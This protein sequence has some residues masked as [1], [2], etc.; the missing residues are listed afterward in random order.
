MAGR[1]GWLRW[2][3]PGDEH[4]S[5]AVVKAV[6]ASHE[7]RNFRRLTIARSLVFA[8]IFVWL[9]VNYGWWVAA[10]NALILG[11]FIANG[12]VA[13]W[14]SAGRD[15]RGW[16]PYVV[17]LV[18]AVLL[19][20]TLIAPGRTYPDEWPWPT[21]LR[22]PSF[23][24]FLLLPAIATLS[25]RPIMVVWSSLCVAFVW[26][27]GTWLIARSEG[28]VTELPDADAANAASSQL[29]AYL[30]PNYVHLDDAVVRVFLTILIGAILAYGAYRA[31]TLM[32]EQAEVVRQR[33][34]LA[35]YVAPNMVEALAAVDRPMGEVRTHDAAVLFADIKGFTALAEAGSPVAAM[36]LLR[37]F[38]GRMA[39]CVFAHG[40]TLDKFIGDGLM[41]TFGTPEPQA[42]AADRAF[43]CGLA[44]LHAIETWQAT[45][46]AAG[47]PAIEVGI[48]IHY[49]PVIMG[50]IGGGEDG[51]AQRFEF[52]VIGD[53]VNVASRLESLTREL[54]EPL[55]VSDTVVQ[56]LSERPATLRSLGSH[57]LDGRSG[58]ITIWTA[59]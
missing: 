4:S 9:W 14:L 19:G 29:A 11:A 39:S 25:F 50:D 13:Y 27:I 8:A 26:T 1:R 40:G 51:L 15:D 2:R 47:E 31:R 37:A 22:Q 45:R 33:A 21:V 46:T 10:D 16:V 36:E 48:G 28:T 57:H 3:L 24:Y 32:L 17:V 41:A 42:D 34:N 5:A 44:M 6:L 35:R 59:R 18:D 58:A 7:E 52:A 38:H 55:L 54:A 20:F 12:L 49:G 23:L 53:T 56:A 30:D 43:A